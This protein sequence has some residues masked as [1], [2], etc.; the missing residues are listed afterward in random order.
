M[1]SLTELIAHLSSAT[2]RFS[3][4]AVCVVST[5]WD[6]RCTSVTASGFA[7]AYTARGRAPALSFVVSFH[8]VLCPHCSLSLWTVILLPLLHVLFFCCKRIS[9]QQSHEL[10][11]FE[12]HTRLWYRVTRGWMGKVFYPPIGCL[13]T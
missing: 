8:A 7:F 13:C 2:E 11:I 4:E 5:S 1:P 6:E 10:C 3:K 12:R 9:S